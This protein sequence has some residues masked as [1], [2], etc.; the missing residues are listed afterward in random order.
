MPI[1]T[2]WNRMLPG[3]TITI[4]QACHEFIREL[5]EAAW[6]YRRHRTPLNYL[7]VYEVLVRM[8]LEGFAPILYNRRN[9]VGIRPC[10][11]LT[12]QE[13]TSE[14]KTDSNTQRT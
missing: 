8:R 12:V 1:E 10:F 3:Q 6:E 4:E 14:R 5:R 11:K 9:I 13:A 7:Q 2:K